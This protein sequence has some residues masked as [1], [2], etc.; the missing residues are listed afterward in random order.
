M[1]VPFRMKS[2]PCVSLRLVL[3]VTILSVS[4]F[5]LRLSLSA[6]SHWPHVSSKCLLFPRSVLLTKSSV[7]VYSKEIK[8]F[9]IEM[10]P[11]TS[12]FLIGFSGMQ[13]SR[14]GRKLVKKYADVLHAERRR[15]DL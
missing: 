8:W 10:S 11:E 4:V 15:E 14:T 13:V 9:T 1:I 3:E 12:H 6:Q 2:F 5:G 7:V